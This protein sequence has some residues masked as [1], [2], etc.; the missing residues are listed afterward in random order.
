MCDND[1][2][3]STFNWVINR[4]R[5]YPNFKPL[6]KCRNFDDVLEWGRAHQAPFKIRALKKPADAVELELPPSLRQPILTLIEAMRT[7]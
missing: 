7:S 6:H 1:V 5:P 4:S 2:G 3:V